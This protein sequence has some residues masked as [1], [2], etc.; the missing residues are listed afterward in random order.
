MAALAAGRPESSIT[1]SST[2]PV[3][4]SYVMITSA[5]EASHTVAGVEP[6]NPATVTVPNP[7]TSRRSVA[8]SASVVSSVTLS[9]L[10]RNCMTNEPDEPSPTPLHVSR[11]CSLRNAVTPSTEAPRTMLPVAKSG[12]KVKSSK[13][14]LG[15]A[16]SIVTTPPSQMVPPVADVT[17]TSPM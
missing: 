1:G 15:S 7:R 13:S 12:T 8:K 9:V 10:P 2:S 11:C 6:S 14:P 5:G 17:V 4:E 3:S 16:N